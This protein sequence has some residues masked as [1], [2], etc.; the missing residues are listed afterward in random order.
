MEL[1]EAGHLSLPSGL[2]LLKKWNGAFSFLLSPL[3]L[4]FCS[5]PLFL[6][7]VCLLLLLLMLTYFSHLSHLCL[8][9]GFPSYFETEHPTSPKNKN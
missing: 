4:E 6:L 3:P 2:W 5:H 8:D 7:F 1:I 9:V